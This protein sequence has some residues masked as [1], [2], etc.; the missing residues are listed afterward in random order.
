MKKCPYCA[1]EIQDEAIVCRHCQRNLSSVPPQITSS[2][3]NLNRKPINTKKVLKWIGIGLLVLISFQIWFITIPV[4]I[5]W[6]LWKKSKFSKQI[7]IIGSVSAVVV[8]F[9][10]E[11]MVSYN[12]RAPSIV[13]TEPQNNT[14]V[15]VASITIKGKANPYTP[16]SLS[17][18][19]IIITDVDKDGNF[20]KE[21]SLNEGVNVLTIQAKNGSN[22]ST[23]TV[24]VTRIL[25]EAEKAEKA[26][27]QAEAEA[28]KQAELEAQKKAQAEADAKAKAEQAAFDATRAGQICKQHPEWS[29]KECQNV[30]DNKYWIG[31]SLDMLKTER[32]LPNNANP[33]NYGGETQWQWCWDDYTP[34]CFYGGSD[35]II[36]SYN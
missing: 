19:G 32:G 34:S 11:W 6:Y 12:G 23:E 35:G 4:A 21:V 20:S 8:F 36:T 10:L 16:S 26:K 15:S 5:I 22:I 13:L 7:K 29:K 31:M 28:K 33:S 18:N 30:A 17:I 1:E 27:E 3:K 2:A 9:L 24:T 14:T 25:T